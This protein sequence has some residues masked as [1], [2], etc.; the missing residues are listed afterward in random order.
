MPT[1]DSRP[2]IPADLRRRV[3]VEAGHRCAIHT[4]RHDNADIHHI[5]P[6]ASCRE[7]VFENLIA[8]CPNCHRRADSGE[9][10]RKALRM[11]KAR[12]AAAFRFE[13]SHVYP[14]EMI[15]MPSF[16]W[17]DSK[18]CWR[19]QVKEE[20]DKNKRFEAQLEYPEFSLY[21]VQTEH[22]NRYIRERINKILGQFRNDV[23]DC[24]D[25]DKN[26]TSSLNFEIS[27]S[28]AVALIQ[29]QLISIRFT[30]HS[31]TGGAHGNN[32]TE[33]INLFIEPFK[34]FDLKDIF[35]DLEVGLISLSSYCVKALLYPSKNGHDRDEDRIRRGTEADEKKF[36]NF[37]VMDQGLLITFNE[38]QI[39][40]YAAGSSEILVPY[41]VFSGNLKE[42]FEK[43]LSSKFY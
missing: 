16:G 35:V 28:F 40:C 22:L 15:S 23:V 43:V 20:Y 24:D 42:R 2:K 3:L 41:S 30:F 37:N 6:W 5:E 25:R 32:W 18:R 4:C 26:L 7:H 29:P 11:Y 38:Y 34:L 19:T 27:S 33:P 39:D 12:L 21:G 10:D 31:Y 17:V 1:E 9:I 36:S 13:E 8:L 14:D